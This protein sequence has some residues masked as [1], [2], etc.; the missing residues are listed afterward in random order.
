[1]RTIQSAAKREN[2]KNA[3]LCV[4][5]AYI[6]RQRAAPTDAMPMVRVSKNIS[7][8]IPNTIVT[9]IGHRAPTKPATVATPLPP[10]PR[11]NSEQPLPNNSMLASKQR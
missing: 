1:M 9:A 11:K 3:L 6:G 8:H 2:K 4:V 5:Y 7:N 10:L